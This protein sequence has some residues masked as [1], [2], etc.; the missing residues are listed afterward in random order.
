MSRGRRCLHPPAPIHEVVLFADITSAQSGP[1]SST[2][3]VHRLQ[4]YTLLHHP[5][6]Q[7]DLAMD[8]LVAYHVDGRHTSDRNLLAYLA[9]EHGVFPS[10][11]I[12]LA[13]LA[14][15]EFDAE[16]KLAYA[17]APRL[18]ITGVPFFVFED[19]W[20]ASGAQSV[21]GFLEVCSVRLRED[22]QADIEGT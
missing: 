15:A 16:V 7:F 21:D 2:H 1:I 19:R 12:A 18:G 17:S 14:G 3:L 8:L 13:W 20:A 4:S 22:V 10:G 5:T 11:D 9:V 6:R